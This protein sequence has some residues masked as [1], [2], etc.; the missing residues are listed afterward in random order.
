MSLEDRVPHPITPPKTEYF[1]RKISPDYWPCNKCLIKSDEDLEKKLLFYSTAKDKASKDILKSLLAAYAAGVLQFWSYWSTDFAFIGVKS[2][3]V[4]VPWIMFH[5]YF[6]PEMWM[7]LAVL[8]S[9]L[10]A[11]ST[12]YASYKAGKAIKQHRLLK[13]AYDELLEKMGLRV[14]YV[15]KQSKSKIRNYFQKLN[16]KLEKYEEQ[17]AKW[18]ERN[19]QVIARYA[20][21]TGLISYTLLEG[22]IVTA[23]YST[24]VG[25][26][27][28][29]PGIWWNNAATLAIGSLVL[30]AFGY[31]A[32]GIY[33]YRQSSDNVKIKVKRYR[34]GE[35]LN[36]RPPA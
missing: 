33:N 2:G 30:T 22:I 10:A 9:G 20:I 8:S 34:P 4:D 7:G 25:T 35:D 14:E 21:P 32:K 1:F 16:E 6:S 13:D 29:D 19:S 18:F 31:V 11:G 24:E 17:F 26:S 12:I 36:P 28:F 23:W 27:T 5:M 15:K 3:G